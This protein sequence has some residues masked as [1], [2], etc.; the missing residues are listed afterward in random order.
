M[1]LNIPTAGSNGFTFI[2]ANAGSMENKGLEF[3]LSTLNID[4]EDFQWRTS[5][6]I[7]TNV[8]RVLDLP[9][10]SVGPDGNRFISGGAAQRAIEGYSINTFFLVR[11]SGVNPQTG[12]AEWLDIDG[13]P[14][15]SPTDSDRVI[16][17]D[18]NPDFV[19][20]IT[21]TFTYKNF[22]LNILAN[23]SY[24]NQVFVQ[25]KQFTDNLVN[26][27]NK[28]TNVLDY[29]TTPGQN[30]YAPALTSSTR[31]IFAR[32]STSQLLDGSYLR[33]NNVTL[34]YN[35]SS[36]IFENSRFFTSARVY[37]TTTNLYTLKN[38]EMA[39]VDPETSGTVGNL[40]QGETFFTPPQS[41]N[42]LLGIRLTF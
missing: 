9:G 22:D 36:S 20:G 7:A 13:N 31:A 16:V 41:K 27:F 25:G 18:A 17:G 37:A 10:A 14:T 12:D 2:S 15:T 35:L 32:S 23:F 21:N 6:N 29:W 39:G 26:D 8:N 34:G 33:I 38:K 5:F 30:A 40:G 3:D 28:T 1:I 4:G 24:G 42:Y 11:Y 19:G